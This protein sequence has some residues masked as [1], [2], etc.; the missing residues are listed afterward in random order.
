MLIHTVP[1][2][3]E[4]WDLGIRS[5]DIIL[6]LHQELD[7]NW[8]SLEGRSRIGY[9]KDSVLTIQRL[10]LNQDLLFFRLMTLP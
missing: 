2:G 9:S 7:E 10:I 6:S 1:E 4:V 3:S 5:R 8:F